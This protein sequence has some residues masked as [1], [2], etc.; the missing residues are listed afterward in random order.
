MITGNDV[1]TLQETLILRHRSTV[2][3]RFLLSLGPCPM[4]KVHPKKPF[5]HR[6]SARY[7]PA[8]INHRCLSVHVPEPQDSVRQSCGKPICPVAKVDPKGSFFHRHAVEAPCSQPTSAFQRPLQVTPRS[9]ELAPWRSLV[10]C[11]CQVLPHEDPSKT[12]PDLRPNSIKR[13][14]SRV[15]FQFCICD[16]R[17]RP[18]DSTTQHCCMAQYSCDK[19]PAESNYPIFGKNVYCRNQSNAKTSPKRSKK[20]R[21]L[22][23]TNSQQNAPVLG[24][25]SS[26]NFW[27]RLVATV[28]PQNHLFRSDCN[29][30]PSGKPWLLPSLRSP[31]ISVFLEKSLVTFHQISPDFWSLPKPLWFARTSIHPSDFCEPKKQKCDFHGDTMY[32]AW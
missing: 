27:N 31:K 14:G 25:S 26:W 20:Y 32:P 10:M 11:H 22:Q 13:S 1:I 3:I 30:W 15:P 24:L 6:D 12:S 4:S 21:I 7:D 19:I 18:R 5:Q 8:W 29:C 9:E 23:K 2:T 17:A 28:D 16:D